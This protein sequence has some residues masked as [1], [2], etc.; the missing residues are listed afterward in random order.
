MMTVRDPME[1]E[2]KIRATALVPSGACLRH[3][4][5]FG[6]RSAPLADWLFAQHVW[7]IPSRVTAYSPD[8]TRKLLAVLLFVLAVSGVALTIGVV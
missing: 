3:P 2:K 5:R 8:G 7:P 4:P 6:R 1:A